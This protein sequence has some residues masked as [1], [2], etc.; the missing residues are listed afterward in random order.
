MWLKESQEED[1]RP[2]LLPLIDVVFLLLIFFMVST[3][4]YKFQPQLSISLPDAVNK[5]ELGHENEYKIEIDAAGKI[6]FE[7]EP[8]TILSLEKK[9]VQLNDEA[10]IMIFADRQ[11]LY[12]QFVNV[13]DL[14]K[15]YKL[16]NV[17]IAV[18]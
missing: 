15:K 5:E 16:S 14:C 6:F 3:H 10:I 13:L 11:I 4:F 8:V 1:F 7:K 9:L 17:A 2:I 12:G 18:R